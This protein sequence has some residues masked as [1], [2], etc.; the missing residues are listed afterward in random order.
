MSARCPVTRRRGEVL[1]EA[2]FEAAL[3]EI[4]ENGLRGASMDRIARRAGTGKS[5]LY[6]RWANVRALALDVFITT[7][8]ENLPSPGADTGSLRGDL[9]A[10]LATLAQHLDGDLGIVL[11][12]LIGE[13]AHD[14]ALSAE[15]QNRFGHDKEAEL[16]AMLSRA[17]ARGEIPV[18][19]VDPVVMQ[20]PAAMVVHQLVLTGRAPSADELEHIIDA[21]VLPLLRQPSTV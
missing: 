14:P 8:E 3:A 12:E 20:V 4:A 1:R 6:R 9:L 2:V 17:M 13:G 11:R 21:I 7:M 18:H 15:F 16:A 19:P 10:A 5:A